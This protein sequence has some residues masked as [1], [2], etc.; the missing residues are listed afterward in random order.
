[1]KPWTFNWSDIALI[2][3]RIRPILTIGMLLQA[4]QTPAQAAEAFGFESRLCRAVV[5]TA[6]PVERFTVAERM[7]HYRVPGA[8][9]AII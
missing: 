9:V 4:S 2:L 3:L 6:R 8:S 5:F 1:M 7:P